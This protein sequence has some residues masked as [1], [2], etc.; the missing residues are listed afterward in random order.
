MVPSEFSDALQERS[1]LLLS[2]NLHQLLSLVHDLERVRVLLDSDKLYVQ[3]TAGLARSTSKEDPLDCP[4]VLKG[5]KE[6]LFAENDLM[7]LKKV[8]SKISGELNG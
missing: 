8:I 1:N 4:F 2:K 7:E 5:L 3:R 6:M